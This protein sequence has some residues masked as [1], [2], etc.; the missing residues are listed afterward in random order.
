LPH[1]QIGL[2][3]G[4]F[5]ESVVLADA[6]TE[7]YGADAWVRVLRWGAEKDS[8]TVTGHAVAVCEARGALWCWDVNFGWKRLEVADADKGEVAKV[9]PEILARYPGVLPRYPVYFAPLAQ[10]PDPSPPSSVSSPIG[11]VQ[12]AD[13]CALALS[14]HRPVYAVT[15]THGEPDSPVSSAA[16]FFA[17]NGQICVYCPENG[18]VACRARGSIRNARLVSEVLH[19]LFPGARDIR[20][21]AG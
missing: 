20:P 21:L 17:Y 1:G 8:E 13:Q 10:E 16:V 9:S 3:N 7:A 15:F 18:T 14:R 2:E 19:R 11:A 5:V 4:C 12:Q 6:F